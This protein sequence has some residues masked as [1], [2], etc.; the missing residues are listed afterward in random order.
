MKKYFLLASLLLFS[1]CMGDKAAVQQSEDKKLFLIAHDDNKDHEYKN[2]SSYFLKALEKVTI[3]HITANNGECVLFMHLTP[4]K[5]ENSYY[6]A[7]NTP[8][9][10]EEIKNINEELEESEVILFEKREIQMNKD[11]IL[12]LNLENNCKDLSQLSVVT[13]KGSQSFE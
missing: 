7:K 11:E 4:Y 5:S 13:N 2:N 6:L 1:A 3:K 12:E 8:A 9:F 10:Q